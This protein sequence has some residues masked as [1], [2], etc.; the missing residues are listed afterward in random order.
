MQD[1]AYAARTLRKS[2]AFAVT[3]MVT[4]ASGVGISTA[5]FSVANAA[6]L[7]QD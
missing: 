5:I 1:F 7:R 4:I 3:A 6:A 2:P